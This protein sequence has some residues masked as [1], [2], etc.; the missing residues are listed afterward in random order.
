MEQAKKRD[1]KVMITDVAIS[2]VPYIGIPGLSEEICRALHEEH[3]EILRIAQQKNDSNEVL[4]VWDYAKD[5]KVRVLGSEH[6]V[7]PTTTPEA[8]GIFTSSSVYGLMYLH[9]HPSTNKFSFA[10]ITEFI[11]TPQIGLLSVVTNQGEVYVLMKSSAYS[12]HI[13][14]DMRRKIS[15]AYIVGIVDD[16]EAVELFLKNCFKGGVTYVKSH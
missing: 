9:N 13:A 5:R 7:N 12:R 4:T 3:K 10:D 16:K 8:Y 2:K 6:Y 15:H 14:N 11:R 1:H